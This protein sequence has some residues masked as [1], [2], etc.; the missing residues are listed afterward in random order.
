NSRGDAASFA[1]AATNSS[2]RDVVRFHT[3]KGKPAFNKFMPMGLPINPRPINPT[4]VCGPITKFT[5][6]SA[7]SKTSQRFYSSSEIDCS[8]FNFC[9]GGKIQCREREME[10]RKIRLDVRCLIVEVAGKS[11]QLLSDLQQIPPPRFRVPGLR[12]LFE[13]FLPRRAAK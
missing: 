11:P 13:R 5:K 10:N 8:V 12:Q 9:E 4:F 3:V 7:L 2:A 1:P 6:T